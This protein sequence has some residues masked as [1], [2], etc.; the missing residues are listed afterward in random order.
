VKS[1]KKIT[2]VISEDS[3]MIS[4]I[5]GLA[6]LVLCCAHCGGAGAPPQTA[7]PQAVSLAQ[8]PFL[9]VGGAKLS[10]YALGSSKPLHSVN[11]SLGAS[12]IAL[13]NR[14]NLFVAN[15]NISEGYIAVYDAQS[16]KLSRSEVL[17]DD[18]FVAVSRRGY[19]YA[20][21]CGGGIDVF[22]PGG[23]KYDYTRY[24]RSGAVCALA[25]DRSDDLFVLDGNSVAI[26]APAQ[27]PGQIKLLR[28]IKSG[29]NG[30]RALTFAP[31]GELFVLNCPRCG[32]HRV[33]PYV[34]I[35]EPGSSSPARIAT[36]DISQP[37]AIAVDSHGTLYVASAP[38]S[39]KDRNP[40]W[41][42]VYAPGTTKPLR[43]IVAGIHFPLGLTLDSLNRLYVADGGNS[44]VTVFSAGGTKLLQTITDGIKGAETLAIH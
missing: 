35:Y 4:R 1:R 17:T 6:A 30:P 31:S 27:P 2:Q 37:A 43:K 28:R 21:N 13:D 12:A 23:M 34:S 44:S 29:I 16:L 25:F 40:G 26:F 36:G 11:L 38:P 7:L 39:Y 3:F 33:P 5:A 32:N 14:G 8:G 42:T 20:S 41:V 18:T 9:Y 19:L 15:G 10:Q 22:T 24:L